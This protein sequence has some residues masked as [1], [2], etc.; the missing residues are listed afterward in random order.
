MAC[1]SVGTANLD[2]T[3][4]EYGYKERSIKISSSLSLLCTLMISYS[5]VSIQDHKKIMLKGSIY[6]ASIFVVLAGFAVVG[7]SSQTQSTNSLPKILNVIGTA[8]IVQSLLNTIFTYFMVRKSIWIVFVSS[9]VLLLS[10]AI[11]TTITLAQIMSGTYGQSSASMTSINAK[12]AESKIARKCYTGLILQKGGIPD[13]ICQAALL[14]SSLAPAKYMLIWSVTAFVF[15]SL[16]IFYLGECLKMSS[17][18]IIQNMRIGIMDIGMTILFVLAFVASYAY[19][20]RIESGDNEL[21]T[22]SSHFLSDVSPKLAHMQNSYQNIITSSNI[23]NPNGSFIQSTNNT[24]LIFENF[25]NGTLL[26]TNLT[27][28][29]NNDILAGLIQISIFEEKY[30]YLN[31]TIYTYVTLTTMKKGLNDTATNTTVTKK[32]IIQNADGTTNTVDLG[33]KSRR[34][35]LFEKRKSVLPVHLQGNGIAQSGGGNFIWISCFT[36]FGSASIINI[37]T[38]TDEQPTLDKCRTRLNNERP[39]LTVEK[40]RERYRQYLVENPGAK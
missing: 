28:K 5:L 17:R 7:Y 39:D 22:F 16:S 23:N 26:N 38:I 10:I 34:R 24:T 6:G 19:L 2:P 1:L 14:D 15:I 35:I 4:E 40:L 25:D 21:L 9:I 18:R 31:Q 3:Q 33:S 11:T 37:N 30:T 8:I 29:T 27:I 20:C 36:G 12:F 13:V 32:L